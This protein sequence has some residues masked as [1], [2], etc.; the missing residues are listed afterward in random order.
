MTST[1]SPAS[2][3]SSSVTT[4]HSGT[5]DRAVTSARKDSM[6]RQTTLPYDVSTIGISTK[7]L[8]YEFTIIQFKVV[9]KVAKMLQI[10]KTQ[11]AKTLIALDCTILHTNLFLERPRR[12]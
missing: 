8:Y 4:A 5:L 1:P 7:H 11:I 9:P 2:V 3:T 12:P 10:L 6:E